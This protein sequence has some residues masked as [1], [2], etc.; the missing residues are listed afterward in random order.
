M[1]NFISIALLICLL[2]TG[3]ISYR[4]VLEL[5]REKELASVSAEETVA[6]EIQSVE[7]PQVDMKA[8]YAARNASETVGTVDGREL[9]W[10]D[11]FYFYSGSIRE[12]ENLMSYFGAYGY[13]L[14]WDDEYEEG[15]TFAE[16]PEEN[17]VQAIRQY[18]AIEAFAQEQGLALSAEEEDALRAQVLSDAEHYCGEGATE[19]Q[20]EAYLAEVY[21][22]LPVYRQMLHTNAVYQKLLNELYG[23]ESEDGSNE[24]AL[25][26]ALVKRLADVDYEPAEGFTAPS[27]KDY[28]A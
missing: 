3:A 10:Q 2:F 14:S 15:I 7:V 4:Q 26:E 12:V 1:K 27:L 6:D 9:T 13:A 8:L 18:A 5:K 16:I 11:Y 21:L 25:S 22:P 23:G 20:L 19:E 24:A 28:L 17:A